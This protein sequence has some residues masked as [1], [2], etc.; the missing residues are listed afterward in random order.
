MNPLNRLSEEGQDQIRKY[1]RFFRQKKD[2]ISRSVN[3]EFIELKNDRLSGEDVFS[4]EDVD[5]Y[6]DYIRSAI[7]VMPCY[8]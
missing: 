3:S 8:L 6:S 2:G 7:K 1:L 5:D 4:K